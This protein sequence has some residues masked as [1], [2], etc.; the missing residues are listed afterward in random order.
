M[1]SPAPA[2]DHR[3]RIVLGL[4]VFLGAMIVLAAWLTFIRSDPT[5]GLMDMQ[6]GSMGASVCQV[7]PAS[8]VDQIVGEIAAPP[9]SASTRRTTTCSYRLGEQPG[10]LEVTYA[11]RVSPEAFRRRVSSLKQ[12]HEV[13]PATGLGASAVIISGGPGGDAGTTLLVLKGSNELMIVTTAARGATTRLAQAILP[14]L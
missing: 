10:A 2:Q 12:R 9:T 8:T 11:M 6:G 4:G 3:L 5:S 14:S 1:A 13:G 7:L